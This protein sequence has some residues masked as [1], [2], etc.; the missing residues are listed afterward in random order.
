MASVLIGLVAP[1]WIANLRGKLSRTRGLLDLDLNGI[2]R[3]APQ[4]RI[5]TPWANVITARKGRKKK[6]GL[7]LEDGSFL[8]FQLPSP[9]S[10]D[11]LFDVILLLV[12][13]HQPPDLYGKQADQGAQGD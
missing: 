4:G 10:R 2:Y 7:D 8:W 5:W 12:Q 9:H 11:Q 6:V 3:E 13:L 1:F